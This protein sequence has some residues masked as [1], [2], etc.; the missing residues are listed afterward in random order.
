MRG[1]TLWTLRSLNW[2]GTGP[3]PKAPATPEEI[4]IVKNLSDS[5]IAHIYQTQYWRKNECN[6]LEDQAVAEKLFDL[7]VNCG[8]GQA[9]K[10]FQRAINRLLWPEVLTEDGIMGP[11]TIAAAN[12]CDQVA[13]LDRLKKEGEAFYKDLA[14]RRPELAENLGGW[15]T[16]VNS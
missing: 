16:R 8:T 3:L 14:A 7:S 2:P 10:F 4:E 9:A 11:R 13:L 6:Y 5:D 12:R 15:L 1:I